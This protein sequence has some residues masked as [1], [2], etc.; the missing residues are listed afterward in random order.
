MFFNKRIK[1]F[2]I[3]AAMS[4]ALMIGVSGCGNRTN[5]TI[6]LTKADASPEWIAK[7]G[8][9]KNANQLFVVAGVGQTTAYVSMHKKDASGNW[10]EIMTTPGC[11]GKLGLGK[12]K[13][14]DAKTPVGDFH[15]N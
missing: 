4:A 1:N 15:F 7:L 12:T 5:Q 11:I 13:E 10:K 9:E 8:E 3:V 6:D 14:G 2:F